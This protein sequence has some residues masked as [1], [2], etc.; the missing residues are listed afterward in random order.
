MPLAL[1][2]KR[3]W[4]RRS[5]L[6]VNGLKFD[7]DFLKIHL[8]EKPVASGLCIVL[9]FCP[10]FQFAGKFHRMVELMAT[11]P[12]RHCFLRY[13]DA[14]RVEHWTGCFTWNISSFFDLG[15]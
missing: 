1:S 2:A 8:T 10:A 14:V 13:F 5:K 7:D 4:F 12:I 15:R 6:K 9:F 3:H 11:I